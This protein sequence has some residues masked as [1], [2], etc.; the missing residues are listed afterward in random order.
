MITRKRIN[1]EIRDLL[2]LQAMVEAYEEIAATRMRRIKNSVLRN[3]EFLSGLTDVFSKVKHSYEQDIA[4]LPKHTTTEKRRIAVLLS[5]NTGLY[6]SIV[7]DTTNAF[8]KY[9]SENDVD[10]VIIGRLGRRL[11]D[12][13]ALNKK[14]TYF[15]LSDSTPD[16]SDLKYVLQHLQRYQTVLV[17]HGKFKDILNQVPTYT[18]VTGQELSLTPIDKTCHISC[19]FEPDLKKLMTFF[20]TQILST[21]FEQ[22][23]YESSLS[24][25]TARMLGLDLASVNINN[26]LTATRLAKRALKHVVSSKQQSSVLAGISLWR[27]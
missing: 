13:A 14:Y 27:G 6:G 11:F 9:A 8:I 20:E 16:I 18:Y 22:A 26:K 15:D 17:F 23:L 7:H 19:I 5:A 2:V 25:F 3:R 10:L 21:L 24:K 4:Q 12:K 1:N